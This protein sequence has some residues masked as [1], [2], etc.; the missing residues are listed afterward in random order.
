MEVTKILVP[1]FTYPIL[2]RARCEKCNQS[3]ADSLVIA[4]GVMQN[5]QGRA[6]FFAET[7]CRRCECERRFLFSSRKCQQNEWWIDVSGW[8]GSDG[9]SIGQRELS[10]RVPV[11][12]STNLLIRTKGRIASLGLVGG[13]RGDT[14]PVML[15]YRGKAGPGRKD[16]GVL[17]LGRRDRVCWVDLLSDEAIPVQRWQWF[18]SLAVGA[19][20]QHRDHLWTKMSRDELQVVVRDRLFWLSYTGD[21]R[22][23]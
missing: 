9:H 20:F 8:V 16:H 2:S 4:A 3:L 5:A 22:K 15:I 12:P 13:Y 19:R 14:G 17:R 23:S 1:P 11:L 21:S 7:R 18:A 6:C 10:S